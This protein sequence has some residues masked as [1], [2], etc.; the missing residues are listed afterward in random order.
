[1]HENM[2]GTCT[3]YVRNISDLETGTGD[4]EARASYGLYGASLYVLITN[5]YE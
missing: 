1:M 3:R 5:G 2:Y 4:E